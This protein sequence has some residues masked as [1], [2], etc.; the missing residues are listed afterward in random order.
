MHRHTKTTHT[1][2]I[3]KWIDNKVGVTKENTLYQS[4]T[5]TWTHAHKMKQTNQRHLSIQGYG[6][7]GVGLTCPLHCPPIR[8]YPSSWPA[9][10]RKPRAGAMKGTKRSWVLWVVPTPFSTSHK[11][12][13]SC[14]GF[15]EDTHSCFYSLWSRTRDRLDAQHGGHS[16]GHLA[17]HADFPN[18]VFF[19]CFDFFFFW[20]SVSLCS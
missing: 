5:L 13:G 11:S 8:V 6:L 10:D 12:S 17:T 2:R 3:K 4:L 7:T 9:Q 1:L 20:D 16:W 15:Q 14:P 18:F 19:A